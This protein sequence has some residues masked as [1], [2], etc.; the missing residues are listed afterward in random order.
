MFDGLGKSLVI[1]RDKLVSSFDR[2]VIGD[3]DFVASNQIDGSSFD[4]ARADFRS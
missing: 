2:V 1:E 3:C 4:F